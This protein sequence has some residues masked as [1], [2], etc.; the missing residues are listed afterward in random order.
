MDRFS[1][2]I[3]AINQYY[4]EL[5]LLTNDEL[6]EK[7]ICIQNGLLSATDSTD[8]LT[9]TL[10]EVYAIIKE[11]ESRF[12]KG[13]VVVTANEKD[14]QWAAEYDFV[15]IEGDHAVYSNTWDVCGNAYTWNMIPYDEQILGGIYLHHGFATE[16]ATGEGKTLVAIFPVFLNALT[17][18][19]VHLMTSN[20]YLSFRDYEQTRPLYLFHGL[21][22]GCI[23]RTPNKR[24]HLLAYRK[25]ITFGSTSTFI[26]DY[27]KDHIALR[28]EDCFQCKPFNFAVID[29]LD[30]ILID[31][32]QTP[33]ILGG[34][35]Y[36]NNGALFIE[37]KPI[38]E[39]LL[40]NKCLYHSDV[41]KRIA[42]FTEEGKTWLREKLQEKKLFLYDKLYK[43]KNFDQLSKE[44]KVNIKHLLSLQGVLIQL[45]FAYTV[46][47]KDV[48][49]IVENNKVV[50]IDENTGRKKESNRWE[51]GLHT[52]VEVKENVKVQDDFEGIAV[53]SVKNFFKLYPKVCGMSGTILQVK[54]ELLEVYGLESVAIATHRPVI[55]MDH[56]LQIFLTREEK[57]QA[58]VS[59]ITAAHQKGR[60]ILIGCASEKDN[61]RICRRLELAN[62]PFRPLNAKSLD[63]EAG[64]IAKAGETGAITVSTSIAGRGT[65]I[66]LTPEAQQTGG[67]LVVG[68]DLYA[69]C[70]IDQQLKGRAGRQ[71][72]PGDSMFFVSAEDDIFKFL[73][74]EKQ[75]DVLAYKKKGKDIDNQFRDY[76]QEAQACSEQNDY[77]QRM[78]S[79]YKDNVVDTF[80][81]Q[82]YIER[83]EILQNVEKAKSLCNQWLAESLFCKD[84]MDQHIH[85]LYEKV[86]SIASLIRANEQQSSKIQTS[87][88][89]IGPFVAVNQTITNN[90][91]LDIPFSENGHLYVLTFNLD[92]L[93]NSEAYF[94]NQY[95]TQSLLLIYDQRWTKF[96][97]YI[98]TDLD[99][100]EIDLLPKRF[101]EM[102]I[103]IGKVIPK[104]LMQSSIP[105]GSTTHQMD[106]LSAMNIPKDH[107]VNTPKADDL[108]PCGSGK[109]YCEC[110]GRDI[111]NKSRKRRR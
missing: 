95:M 98:Q 1:E 63:K 80:R 85:Q 97:E 22:V 48:D 91:E 45:L 87:Y 81:K 64:I 89:N 31:T 30:S 99:K 86:F 5:R 79:A 16:M 54:E 12:S 2:Q 9:D 49:Y 69:S 10:I 100:N 17:R 101:K 33:H 20:D 59:K 46:Y 47:Q 74:K 110:H 77:K 39:E 60:P 109:K 88:F 111:R 7:L 28:P 84:E 72:D 27:L 107:I 14:R 104:R 73:P 70:R 21:S 71:G 38:I 51:H 96:V 8:S 105:V 57:I 41:F 19:G 34:G 26:F 44:E 35:S 82:F 93:L 15:K 78:E 25:D 3:A 106:Y 56:P 4:E 52:A 90:E 36:Y 67:L 62:V 83:N 42:D 65:D 102:Y 24:A 76:V 43:I 37:N 58:I 32:A 29:E 55:R 11:T 61:V 66:K 53:I 108:C 103:K 40:K 18:R 94:Y 23:E 6:R 13:A 75:L 68:V 92:K 50:I